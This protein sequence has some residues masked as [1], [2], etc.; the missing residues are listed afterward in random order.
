MW[1]PFLSSRPHSRSWNL[2]ASRMP[3]KHFVCFQHLD[4]VHCR[5]P[6]TCV[7]SCHLNL[8][9]PAALTV[10]YACD[11]SW[12]FKHPTHQG[13]RRPHEIILLDLFPSFKKILLEYNW[14]TILCQL[15]LKMR[16][17]THT[18]THTF[19]FLYYLPS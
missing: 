15:L 4:V 16:T 7:S 1:D 13:L 8:S 2:G 6:S 5:P 9:E 3:A 17:H 12:G 10:V 11:S 14:F 18:H 19:L